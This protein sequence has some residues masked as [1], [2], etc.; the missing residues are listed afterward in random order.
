M[1]TKMIIISLWSLQPINFYVCL[2]L[3]NATREMKREKFMTS[4]Y[5][6]IAHKRRNAELY[7]ET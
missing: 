1:K 7:I 6:R 2:S 3:E 5:V 4:N